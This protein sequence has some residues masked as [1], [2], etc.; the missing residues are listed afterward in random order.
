MS[1]NPSGGI[2]YICI[3][4]DDAEKAIAG[5]GGA[6]LRVLGDGTAKPGHHGKSFFPASEGYAGRPMEIEETDE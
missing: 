4:T 3:E 2:H 1:Q 5:A 6:G